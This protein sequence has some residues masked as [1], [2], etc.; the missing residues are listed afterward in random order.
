M[1]R[2]PDETARLAHLLR[3]VE[4]LENTR[5][6]LLDRVEKT[7]SSLLAES[8]RAVAIR[9]AL[10]LLCDHVTD[11]AAA[12]V[13]LSMLEEELLEAGQHLEEVG[14]DTTQ[15]AFESDSLSDT[16]NEA[17]EELERLS[18]VLAER[19]GKPSRGH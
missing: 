8:D 13:E 18:S 1:N 4:E 9:A 14:K 7:R 5:K 19:R 6:A 16:L 10:D 3:D 12:A 2:R 17:D 15:F 11:L